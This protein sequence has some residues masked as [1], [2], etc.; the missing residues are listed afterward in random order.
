MNM[1]VPAAAIATAAPSAAMAGS[2]QELLALVIA[3][4]EA[5]ERA[6]PLGRAFNKVETHMIA[7]KRLNPE[8]IRPDESKPELLRQDGK[9]YVLVS[10][11]KKNQVEKEEY[12]REFSIWAE[13]KKVEKER[14]GFKKAEAE[15]EDATQEIGRI[16]REIADTSANTLDG[17]I[18]KARVFERH[19]FEYASSIIEDLIEIGDSAPASVMRA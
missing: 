7:W 14:C 15:W 5:E 19:D 17:L 18:A 12:E 8:P 1:M 16:L 6:D 9:L 13:R 3:L 11:V 10:P 2:N 4:E